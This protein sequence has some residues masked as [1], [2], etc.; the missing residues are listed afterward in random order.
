MQCRPGTSC[1]N[2]SCLPTGYE[3]PE[4]VS[5][6][7][8]PI[9]C[10]CKDKCEG[11]VA[12]TVP[13]DCGCVEQGDCGT[14]CCKDGKCRPAEECENEFVK[15]DANEKLCTKLVTVE[16]I[17]GCANACKDPNKKCVVVKDNKG[18]IIGCDCPAGCQVGAVDANNNPNQCIP[19]CPPGEQ[20]VLEQLAGPPE[21]VCTNLDKATCYDYFCNTSNL[22]TYDPVA[23]SNCSY[24]EPDTTDY[25]TSYYYTYG[26][27]T[28][29]DAPVAGDSCCGPGEK[30]GKTMVDGSWVDG[31]CNPNGAGVITCQYIDNQGHGA[32]GECAPIE[33]DEPAPAPAANPCCGDGMQCPAGAVCVSG[34]CRQGANAVACELCPQKPLK[35]TCA[36]RAPLKPCEPTERDA[37]G[38]P[39]MCTITGCAQGTKCALSYD[40]TVDVYKDCCGP[41]EKCGKTMVDGS[42]VDG[43]CNPNGM[44]GLSCQY[45]NNQGHGAPGECAPA[46]AQ[47]ACVADKL[48]DAA[49]RDANGNP[50]MCSTTGCPEGQKCELSYDPTADAYKDCCGPGEKCGKM[51]VDGSWVDGNCNPNGMGGLSCQY[52]NNQGHGAPGECAPADAQCRCSGE[53]CKAVY[54]QGKGFSCTGGCASGTGSCVLQPDGQSC[55]CSSSSSS[56]SG[57]GGISYPSCQSDIDCN[58]SAP[59]VYSYCTGGYCEGGTCKYA[60][61]NDGANCG[62]NGEVCY[63]GICQPMP[64]S[65]YYYQPAQ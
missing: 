54:A 55:K 47:C 42:W 63:A 61:I 41:G 9:K 27:S 40:P 31:N 34:T 19:G 4:C 49:E 17:V 15:V 62:P 58:P 33:G 3:G 14:G 22:D 21:P 8:P 51:M 37:N 36:C 59:P 26:D 24:E 30:C 13:V 11:T 18:E 2:Y 64:T 38:N 53:P 1:V 20:C 28:S 35:N 65:S 7:T 5:C 56:G 6:N 50:T 46:D 29:V 25:V 44:G 32:P 57:S 16:K 60:A 52:I 12:P 39:T 48:C 43:N 45:I 23:C 10:V